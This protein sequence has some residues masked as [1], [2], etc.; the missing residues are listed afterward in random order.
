MKIEDITNYFDVKCKNCGSTN[1]SADLAYKDWDDTDKPTSLTITC[2][3]CYN[4]SEIE[5]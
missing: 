4:S 5:L 3:N 1:L 2:N